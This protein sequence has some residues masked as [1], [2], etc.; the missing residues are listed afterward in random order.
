MSARI[1]LKHRVIWLGSFDGLE[2][3]VRESL[4]WSRRGSMR[5]KLKTC[6]HFANERVGFVGETLIQVDIL[7]KRDQFLVGKQWVAW[8]WP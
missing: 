5:K 4:F 7:A 3:I 8:L 6:R 1:N 2:V